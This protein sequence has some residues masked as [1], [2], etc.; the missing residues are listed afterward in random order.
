[1]ELGD[2][3]VVEKGGLVLYFLRYKMALLA[4]VVEVEL[5]ILLQQ[6]MAE[7]AGLALLLSAIKDSILLYKY[8]IKSESNE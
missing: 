1:L 5:G 6:R 2:S 8:T 7:V 3:E 4:P